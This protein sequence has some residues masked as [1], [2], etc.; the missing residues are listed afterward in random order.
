MGFAVTL[1]TYSNPYCC[2]TDDRERRAALISRD[3]R[4]VLIVAIGAVGG[5]SRGCG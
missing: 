1:S 3:V 4:L 2:F 5:T